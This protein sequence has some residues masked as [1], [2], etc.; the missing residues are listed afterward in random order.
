MLPTYDHRP[1]G[2]TSELISTANI[3]FA[4]DPRRR[5]PAKLCLAVG[6]S[7]YV[8]VFCSN[9]LES[10]LKIQNEGLGEASKMTFI[11]GF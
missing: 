6:R 4:S 7:L 9:Q 8:A 2:S 11:S 1:S 5:G 3:G 10:K